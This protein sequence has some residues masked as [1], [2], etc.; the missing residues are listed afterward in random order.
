MQP[1]NN[2]CDSPHGIQKKSR[3]VVACRDGPHTVSRSP[4]FVYT[5]SEVTIFY[6]VLFEDG[7]SDGITIN[8]LSPELNP[9]CYLLAFLTHHFLHVSKIIV[10]ILAPVFYI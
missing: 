1:V 2:F 3:N 6:F 8:P 10:N 5:Y 9:I 7:H 4:C